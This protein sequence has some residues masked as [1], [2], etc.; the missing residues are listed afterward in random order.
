MIAVNTV[1][2][3]LV[4]VSFG[5]GPYS[6]A[7]QELW[8]RYGS[9]GFFLGGSVLPAIALFTSRR[10]MGLG[11]ITALV[12]WLLIILFAFAAFV[13]MSGGGV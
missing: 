7:G 11:I 12:V 13:M 2:M 4:A 3:G 1:L 8:Y 10:S 9:V 6:T 5:S